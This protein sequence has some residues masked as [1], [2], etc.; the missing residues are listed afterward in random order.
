M[1]S[2]IIT[3]VYSRVQLST[4]I[5]QIEL[6]LLAVILILLL[7]GNWFATE[8]FVFIPVDLLA[9]LSLLGWWALGL[10]LLAFLAWCIGDD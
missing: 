1:R 2:A 7:I 8:A 4:V 9:R 6:M 5:N 10:V 3:T